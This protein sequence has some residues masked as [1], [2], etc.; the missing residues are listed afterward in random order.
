MIDTDKGTVDNRPAT[1]SSDMIYYEYTNKDG[2][3][4]TD[5]INRVTG[6]AVITTTTT[7]AIGTCEK[8]TQR[9]F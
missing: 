5:R 1:I 8:A 3:H 4:Y 7:L 6:T 9:K 2:T